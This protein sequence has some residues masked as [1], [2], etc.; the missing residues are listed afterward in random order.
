MTSKIEMR[1][2]ESD[3]CCVLAPMAGSSSCL[4]MTFSTLT[5]P[6][7][8]GDRPDYLLYVCCV[9][10]PMA[11][12]GSCLVMTFSTLT[13]PKGKGERVKFRRSFSVEHVRP[14]LSMLGVIGRFDGKLTVSVCCN[15]ECNRSTSG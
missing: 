2:P 7:G 1:M 5:S 3:V 11:G 13:S 10:A 4:V 12:S 9:L 8:K 14:R 6:K 15:E